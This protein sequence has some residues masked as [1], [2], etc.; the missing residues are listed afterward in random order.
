MIEV[1]LPWLLINAK[2]PSQ[3]EFMG[4]MYDNGIEDS[5]FIEEIFVGALHV[6]DQGMVTDSLPSMDDH[7]LAPLK[8]YAWEYWDQPQFAE[9]LK[10]SYYTIKDLFSDD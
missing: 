3:K 9:R 2:D 4:R 7:H 5:I 10:Q 1:R 6:D 8:G